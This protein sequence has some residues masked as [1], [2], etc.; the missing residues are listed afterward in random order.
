M[1][2]VGSNAISITPQF[3]KLTGGSIPIVVTH[4]PASV[5]LAYGSIS[6]ILSL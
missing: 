6:P 1:Q 3:K 4:G 2:D 5:A